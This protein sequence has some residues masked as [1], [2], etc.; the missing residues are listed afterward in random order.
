MAEA[1]VFISYAGHDSDWVRAF[2]AGLEREHLKVLLR[3]RDVT[4]GDVVLHWVEAAIGTVGTAVL[5]LSA[6]T[7]ADPQV[8]EEYAAFIDQA[9]KRQLR[10]IPVLCGNADVEIPPILATRLSVDFR[11]LSHADHAAKV[12][13]LAEVICGGTWDPRSPV[14]GERAASPEVIGATRREPPRRPAEPA[15]P[16]FVVTYAAADARYGERLVGWLKEHDLPAWSIADLAWGSEYIWEIR[17]QIQHALALV[18]LMSPAAEDSSD[19]EREIL[20]GQRHSRRFFPLLVQGERHF[21]LASSWCFDARGGAWPGSSELRTLQRI[22]DDHVKGRTPVE[23]PRA[24]PVWQPG[25][26]PRRRS[27]TEVHRLRTFL[28]EGELAH[29]DLLTTNMLLTAVGR[30]EWGWLD[31]SDEARLPE[32]LLTEIDNAWSELTA[33]RQGFRLQRRLHQLQDPYGGGFM[34]LA[35]ALGWLSPP[36]GRPSYGEIPASP[37][38]GDLLDRAAVAPDGFFPTLRNP[39]VEQYSAWPDQWRKTVLAVHQRLRSWHEKSD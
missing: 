38:Y 7:I 31:E 8:S 3:E 34:K 2:V 21:L 9:R 35:T 17:Q 24:L 20:E 37:E 14:T 15:Q 10:L 29:A 6:G 32:A 12:S 19:V 30:L 1:T 27:D 22:H 39:Q 23:P 4:L 13:R 28:K 33:Q 26:L 11:G 25:T 5:V 18:V 16:S 36:D